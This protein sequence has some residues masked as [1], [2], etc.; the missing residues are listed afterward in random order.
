MSNE[1]LDG[2]DRYS[3]EIDSESSGL[4]RSNRARVPSASR[5]PP[6]APEEQSDLAARGITRRQLVLIIA[7]NAMISGMI[8]LCL[9]LLMRGPQPPAP[10]G[11]ETP[12][13]VPS[14]VPVTVAAE[15]PAPATVVQTPEVAE[16]IAEA[17]PTSTTQEA[18]AEP[19]ATP[20]AVSHVVKP[21]DTISG[22]AFKYDVPEEHIIIANRL[23]NPNFLQ[24]GGELII[25]VGGLPDV[26]ATLTAVPSATS[27]PIPFEPPSA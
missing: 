8:S 15:V 5:Q 22:L 12:I 6:S 3:D 14:E 11:H 7:V 16:V 1:H 27:T 21:G 9:V 13:V 26:T 4:R 24:M 20:E 10:A 19:S 2:Q 17:P 18:A 23:K 25:P